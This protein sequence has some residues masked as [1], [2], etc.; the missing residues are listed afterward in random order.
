MKRA[1]AICLAL[2]ACGPVSPEAAADQC[3]ERAQRAAGP[4]G[5]A[6]IGVNSDKGV[7]GGVELTI[8]SDFIRGR[9]PQQVYETCVFNLTGQPPVRPLVLR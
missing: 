5:E 6:R 8:G 3:E 9:D 4:T 1:L 7:V 2:V